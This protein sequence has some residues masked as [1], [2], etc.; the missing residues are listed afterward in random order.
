MRAVA[1]YFGENV[2]LTS[3]EAPRRIAVLKTF[4]P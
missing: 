2:V 4:G 1:G 3:A